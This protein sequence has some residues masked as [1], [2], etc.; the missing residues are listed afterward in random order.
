M[1]IFAEIKADV[2]GGRILKDWFGDGGIPVAQVDAERRA[3]TCICC[4]EN[5]PGG[6]W[7]NAK[8]RVARAIREQIEMKNQLSL[9]VQDEESL[10]T[11]R[12]CL[13]N[14]PLKV[15]V[16]IQYILEHTDDETMNA[17]PAA[18]WIKNK[19]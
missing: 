18:C 6:W 15:H 8:G 3:M 4:K 12:V 2:K 14:L 1:N 10:G 16:P 7:E 5:Q 9:R 19:Q 11:C 13:C 17:F